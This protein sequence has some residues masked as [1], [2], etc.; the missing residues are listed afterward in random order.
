VKGPISAVAFQHRCDD[1]AQVLELPGPAHAERPARALN[2]GSMG[3]VYALLAY[4]QGNTEN[5]E[6]VVDFFIVKVGDGR[7]WP[8]GQ[9]IMSLIEPM[10]LYSRRSEAVRDSTMHVGEYLAELVQRGGRLYRPVVPPVSVITL[11]ALGELVSATLA[12]RAEDQKARERITK[13]EALR[14]RLKRLQREKQRS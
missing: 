2:A 5:H 11:D 9:E 4:H 14:F 12:R 10:A 13:S 7:I 1:L 3:N 8:R 6:I